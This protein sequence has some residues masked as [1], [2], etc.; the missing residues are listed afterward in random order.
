MKQNERLRSSSQ[1]ALQA[2]RQ[3]MTRRRSSARVGVVTGLLLTTL[4]ARSL[5]ARSRESR[6][7]PPRLAGA[8]PRRHR[9]GHLA[10]GA[11]RARRCQPLSWDP[12]GRHP[13]AR[14]SLPRSRRSERSSTHRPDH[15]PHEGGSPGPRGEAARRGTWGPPGEQLRG[16]TRRLRRRARR[17]HPDAA[18]R[19]LVS[20]ALVTRRSSPGAVP[21]RSLGRQRPEGGTVRQPRARP[22]GSRAGGGTQEA[23]HDPRHPAPRH[24]PR[25]APGSPEDGDRVV[26]RAPE[27]VA[28]EVPSPGASSLERPLSARSGY[29]GLRPPASGCSPPQSSDS[30]TQLRLA[31]GARR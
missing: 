18:I 3:A 24:R 25:G 29:G 31:P 5:P 15:R 21:G 1:T 2:P 4:F 6:G 27:E 8:S 19:A 9:R 14:P 10:R 13:G 7:C 26:R 11:R 20:Q 30:R 17:S 28:R 16:G 12:T 22:P 23:G